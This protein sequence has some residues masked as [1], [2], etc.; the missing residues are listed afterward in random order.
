MLFGKN[1]DIVKPGQVF[2][3]TVST[4]LAD[5]DMQYRLESWRNRDLT[6]A[7]IN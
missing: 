7:V 1:P 2:I 4:Y 6:Q 3:N 5:I